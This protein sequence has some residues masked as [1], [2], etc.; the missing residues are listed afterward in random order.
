MLRPVKSEGGRHGHSWKTY[1]ASIPMFQLTPVSPYVHN[2]TAHMDFSTLAF[3]RVTELNSPILRRARNIST[4]PG[5]TMWGSIIFLQQSSSL[6]WHWEMLGPV[7]QQGSCPT[8]RAGRPLQNPSEIPP[9]KLAV[10][11]EK[12]FL[13]NP[14]Q[15]R[16][17]NAQDEHAISQYT[18]VSFD[19]MS[20]L[21]RKTWQN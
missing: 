1:E 9:G 21:R 20:P 6:E 19:E 16:G 12:N 8:Q 17:T 11:L 3:P 18:F 15:V 14:N 7:T 4:K 13:S 10:P 2:T 5:K